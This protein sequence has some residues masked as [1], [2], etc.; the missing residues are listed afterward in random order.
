MPKVTERNQLESYFL[1][2][3]L[4]LRQQIYDLHFQQATILISEL[5]E[6]GYKLSAALKMPRQMP[7]LASRN[8]FYPPIPFVRKPIPL[9]RLPLV[10]RQIY[11]ETIEY[12][13]KTNTFRLGYHKL[14]SLLPTL[15]IFPQKHMEMLTSLHFEFCI[16]ELVKDIGLGPRQPNPNYEQTVT[17]W[18]ASSPGKSRQ[19][20]KWVTLWTFL[21]TLPNLERLHV[22]FIQ[23]PTIY[24][25]SEGRAF[26]SILAPLLQFNKKERL[27]VFEVEW[28][29]SKIYAYDRENWLPSES[30]VKA[31]PFD[32][33]W[34]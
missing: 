22:L 8:C 30:L 31:I 19:R 13:Y 27:A 34:K 23:F 16:N 6:D 12:V 4:E 33:T 9:L 24:S 7:A 29:L 11:G 3:P 10:C 15:A 18:T 21:T 25:F 26:W 1:K 2:L 20:R 5:S 28:Q 17:S 32:L 14:A